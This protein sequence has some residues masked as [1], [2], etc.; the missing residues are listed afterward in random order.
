MSLTKK[1]STDATRQLQQQCKQEGGLPGGEASTTGEPSFSLASLGSNSDRST[2]GGVR[3]HK[4]SQSSTHSTH[5]NASAPKST[6]FPLPHHT[7]TNTHTSTHKHPHT[8]TNTP[9]IHPQPPHN[10]PTLPCPEWIRTTSS[11]S[12]LGP[13]ADSPR[14]LARLNL[15]CTFSCGCRELSG[16]GW[17]VKVTTRREGYLVEK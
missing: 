5:N 11:S 14:P 13:T 8:P 10:F 16:S 15:R 17:E 4:G 12:A 7:Q 2:S 9:H 6:H 3:I 1:D